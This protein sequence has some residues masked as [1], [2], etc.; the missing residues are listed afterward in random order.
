MS[1]PG[2]FLFEIIIILIFLLNY[3]QIA[4]AIAKSVNLDLAA[5][6]LGIFI[7]GCCPGGGASNM[8][9]YLL[10]GDLSLS[11]TM[12]ALSTILALGK[13]P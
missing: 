13:L 8:Y 4:F 2:L 5:V 10:R 12:T 3:F 6:S 11:I 9:S 7:A 1:S